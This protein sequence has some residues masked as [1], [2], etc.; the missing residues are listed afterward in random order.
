ML[1]VGKASLALTLF[2]AGSLAYGVMPPH[3]RVSSKVGL[4][5]PLQPGPVEAVGSQWGVKKL[6]L[7]KTSCSLGSAHT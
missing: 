4:G 3:P 5:Q 7:M 1:P 2:S 6:E